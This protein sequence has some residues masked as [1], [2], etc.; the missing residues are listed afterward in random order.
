MQ[1]TN[2]SLQSNRY[3]RI[4]NCKSTKHSEKRAKQRGV[5]SKA[6]GIVLTFGVQEYDGKGGIR[7]QLTQDAMKKL[8]ATCG[9]TKELEAMAGVYVVVSAEDSAVITVGHRYQ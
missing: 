7:Y 8:Y 2:C 3:T 5:Q 9:K 1:Y 6:V 4:M